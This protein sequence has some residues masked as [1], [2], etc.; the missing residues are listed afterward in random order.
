M[1]KQFELGGKTYH[2]NKVSDIAGNRMGLCYDATNL[3]ELATSVHNKPVPNSS[4]EQ[5]LYHEVLHSILD[6]LGY[7]ALSGDETFV[8]SV[9]C[10]LHQFDKTKK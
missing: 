10:L 5:T 2:V 1:I 7:E 9:A 8:Q 6:S 3:I 4:M